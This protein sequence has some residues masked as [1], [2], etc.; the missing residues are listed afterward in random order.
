MVV[1]DGRQPHRKRVEMKQ[2]HL[3]FLA[4]GSSCT[5]QVCNC[6][7]LVFQLLLL[8]MRRDTKIFTTT[9]V[10]DPHTLF[11]LDRFQRII[12][13]GLPSEPPMVFKTIS[14]QA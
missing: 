3:V 11:V 6:P 12:S 10:I 4:I 14:A 13:H 9:N 7:N 5:L 1:E 8:P 2:E